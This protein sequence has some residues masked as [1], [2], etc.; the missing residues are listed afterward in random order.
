MSNHWRVTEHI[1]ILNLQDILDWRNMFTPILHHH[2]VSS[3]LP[4]PLLF[5]FTW[6]TCTHPSCSGPDSYRK[7]PLTVDSH[8]YS[9]LPDRPLYASIQNTQYEWC[10]ICRMSTPL[11][12]EPHEG[13]GLDLFISQF[14][15][16]YLAHSSGFTTLLSKW[17]I[18][19]AKCTDFYSV[20]NTLLIFLHVLIH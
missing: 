9:R 1:S 18:I 10:V 4:L 16:H 11:D 8:S 3:W 14:P 20:P 6:L 13:K 15:A 7:S 5:F 2:H 12:C 19:I 17:M